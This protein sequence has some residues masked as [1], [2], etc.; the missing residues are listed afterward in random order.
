MQRI[1]HREEQWEFPFVEYS[2]SKQMENPPLVIQLH[3]AGERGTGKEDLKLVDVHGFSK[4]LK[5]A[6]HDC[7]VIMPQCPLESFWAARVESIVRFVEQLIEAYGAD[8][9]RVYLTGLSMGGYGTWFTS[10]A[11][12]DLFAAIAP[13][14]GGGMA[15]N[16]EVLKMPIWAFH[17]AEDDI[18]SPVQS[19]EMVAA[20]KKAGADVTY[21]RVDGVG[22][23]VWDYAYNQELMNWLLSKKR[24]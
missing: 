20:L 8:K 4:Y 7:I 16:A 17:G 15:W 11:R 21:T 22:H 23:N 18:V 5:D 1:E 14:C 19:D 10:M 9:D 13:I 24:G 12:P 3:G 6:E 2:G